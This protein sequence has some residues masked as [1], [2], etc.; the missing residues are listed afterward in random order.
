VTLA[1][2]ARADADAPGANWHASRQQPLFYPEGPEPLRWRVAVGAQLDIL[3]RRVV[4]DELR[5]IPELTA[6]ARLGLPAGFSVDLRAS[7][8]VIANQAGLGVGWS[9]HVGPLSFGVVDHQ[10]LWFGYVGTEG[11]DAT[12]WGLVNFPGIQLGLPMGAVRFSLLGEAIFTFAQHTTLGDASRT[13]RQ[14]A[15]LAGTSLTLTVENILDSG[16]IIYFGAA[17]LRAQPD[18]QAWLAFSDDT[19]RLPYP[20]FFGGYAF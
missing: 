10:G 5:E 1:T 2:A 4:E 18:Y 8:N 14:G 11:F 19:T 20:R 13:S 9:H 7:A 12:G 3:P 16:G 15:V 17:L 6:T